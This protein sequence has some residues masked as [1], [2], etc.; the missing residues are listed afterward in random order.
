MTSPATSTTSSDRKR[1]RD[2]LPNFKFVG[3]NW[4]P[5]PLNFLTDVP[6]VLVHRQEIFSD[7]HA[8]NTGVT[9]ILPR[10]DWFRSA[11][12][13]AVFSFNGAGELTG[14][15]WI[16]ETGLLHS[17]IVLTNSYSVGA[18]Y[19][20]IYE[21]AISRHAS[22]G[23][24]VDWLLLPVVG[25]TFDGYV[26]DITR[27]PVSSSHVVHGIE[28]ASSKPVKEGNTGGGTG[29]ICHSF[30]GGTGS[31]SRV[32]P[33]FDTEQQ[34]KLYTVSV[35]V[36]ANYGRRSH[37]RIGN[38]PVGQILHE[39]NQQASVGNKSASQGD[40]DVSPQD[41]R[42]GRTDG[43]IIVIIATDAP[44]H[45]LQLERLAKRATV[46]LARVGGNGLNGCGDIFLAFSTAHHIPVQTASAV[47]P[48]KPSPNITAAIDDA[49]INALFEAVADATEE[50]I[51]NAL[52]MA[53]TLTGHLG[54]TL[55]ALPQDKVKNIVEQYDAFQTRLSSNRG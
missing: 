19:Q 26:N 2:L 8:E 49:T 48:F 46:G 53:E 9:C 40:Q 13:A 29:N 25:E 16:R 15:H 41:K 55:E 52:C 24:P 35:L 5:G 7:D 17:P 14:S 42:V 31:S 44:L 20:G 11:C 4:Q 23:E 27:L 36:Q 47:D 3:S 50:S 43:S 28:R 54:H 1:L 12:Y 10:K 39:Q 32:I 21:Y 34:D 30:K 6:G 33:G 51:L 18:A 38:V 37:L 22:P 45:P